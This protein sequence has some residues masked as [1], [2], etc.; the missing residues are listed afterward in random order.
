MILLRN[1]DWPHTVILTL[2][3]TLIL[4][5]PP[6]ATCWLSSR[7]QNVVSRSSTEAEF[8]SLSGALFGDAV[9]MLGVWECLLPDVHLRIYEDNQA[10]IAIVKKGYSSKLRHL[11]T[12]HRVNMATTCE[13][14]NLH[15]NVVL[16]YCKADEQ[17]GDPLTK[18]LPLQKWNHA[19]GLLNIDIACLPGFH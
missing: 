3:A 16:H 2:Q 7:R 19:Q 8:V 9:P 6:V 5:V 10:C 11:A 12:T 13:L 14:V 17:R 4:H 1:C 18:I 15:D